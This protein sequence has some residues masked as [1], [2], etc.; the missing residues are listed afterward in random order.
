MQPEPPM[1]TFSRKFP[2][3]ITAGGVALLLCIAAAPTLHAQEEYNEPPPPPGSFVPDSL[4]TKN[5]AVSCPAGKTVTGGGYVLTGP[6]RG[7][8][9][10]NA[11]F[12][13]DASTWYAEAHRF[14]V[15]GDWGIDV[16]AVCVKVAP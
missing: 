1:N 16:V 7:S 4:P 8:V 2:A 12:P 5:Y 15:A 3:T 13:F 10:A 9:L 14:L 6:D 11:S